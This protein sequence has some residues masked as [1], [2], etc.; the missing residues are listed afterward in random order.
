LYV[1]YNA[2][3]HPLRIG[4]SGRGE[5][6]VKR[7]LYNDYHRWKEW[8]AVDHFS[9]FTFTTPSWADQAERLILRAVGKAL[10]EN[11]NLG[12]VKVRSDVIPPPSQRGIP[13]DFVRRTV[14][15]DGYVNVGKKHARRTVRVE[16]G[17]R[18]RT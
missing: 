10:A 7:R 6:D 3:G 14:G 8:R 15:V 17:A 2:K 1:L 12:A 11:V 13:D 4:I 5:Q 9:V 16:V 18:A